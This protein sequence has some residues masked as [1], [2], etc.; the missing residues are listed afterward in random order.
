MHCKLNKHPHRY[1]TTPQYHPLLGH[2]QNIQ[3]FLLH[4]QVLQRW[5]YE[6]VVGQ[7]DQ[8]IRATS[9][10]YIQTTTRSLPDIE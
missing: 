8:V 9:H 4:V 6:E 3:Q 5:H 2:A 10:A 1:R 7:T